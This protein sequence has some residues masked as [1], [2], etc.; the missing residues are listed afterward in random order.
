MLFSGDTRSVGGQA[1][2][3]L[4]KTKSLVQATQSKRA[5]TRTKSLVPGVSSLST[6]SGHQ[7]QDPDKLDIHRSNSPASSRSL[8]PSLTVTP[9][10]SEG[11]SDQGRKSNHASPR[12]SPS[13]R[14]LSAT[15]PGRLDSA[16]KIQPEHL[17]VVHEVLRPVLS[18]PTPEF[19]RRFHLHQYGG[20]NNRPVVETDD[21]AVGGKSHLV[22]GRGTASM[23]HGQY[24]TKAASAS[25]VNETEG[26]AMHRRLQRQLSLKGAEDPRI[27]RKAKPREHV[28]TFR[29]HGTAGPIGPLVH[30][31]PQH[32]P[33]QVWPSQH[34]AM[35]YVDPFHLALYQNMQAQIDAELQKK[36]QHSLRGA[37]TSQNNDS[38]EVSSRMRELNNTASSTL[39]PPEELMKSHQPLGKMPSAPGAF[40]QSDTRTQTGAAT[41]RMNRQ[42]STSDSS[43]HQS[44]DMASIM[45]GDYTYPGMFG[46][47]RWAFQGSISGQRLREPFEQNTKQD[48]FS[49]QTPDRFFLLPDGS[50]HFQQTTE[51]LELRQGIKVEFGPCG[52]RQ[53]HIPPGR[54][55]PGAPVSGN[56]IHPG[57]TGDQSP[58]RGHQGLQKATSRNTVASSVPALMGSHNA[59][60]LVGASQVSSRLVPSEKEPV[61]GHL[62]VEK[63]EQIIPIEDPRHQIYFHLCGLFDEKKVLQVM[64]AYP[65]ETNPQVLCAYLIGIN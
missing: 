52:E 38:E 14:D 3:P 17:S 35:Q 24:L 59:Q 40:I 45:E 37:G 27:L 25:E 43:L 29:F 21:L 26:Q 57:K 19:H 30:Q 34:L 9:A 54:A 20:V 36:Q 47:P 49:T 4:G 48:L 65:E 15:A 53:G 64:T 7:K 41:P 58:V 60:G 33:Q 23:E 31:Q 46:D 6:D 12:R 8:S 56:I 18:D 11:K 50:K 55:T 13:P 32:Q 16:V 62:S 63:S 1:K 51:D 2:K 28:P 39:M 10:P 44:K 5:L 22:P 61:P 42:N